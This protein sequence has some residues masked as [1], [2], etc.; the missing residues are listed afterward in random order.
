MADIKFSV[1]PEN[2]AELSRKIGELRNSANSSAKA[3]TNCVSQIREGWQ[4]EAAEAYVQAYDD[5]YKKLTNALDSIQ[6]IERALSQIATSLEEE[7]AND[8]ASFQ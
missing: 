8:A 1:T 7:D 4:G 5:L 3:I 6:E 2:V